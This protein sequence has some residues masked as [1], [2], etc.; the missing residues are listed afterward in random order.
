VTRKNAR[1]ENE[2]KAREFKE[3]FNYPLPSQGKNLT[4][5]SSGN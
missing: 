4:G 2:V 3:S 5:L 1:K